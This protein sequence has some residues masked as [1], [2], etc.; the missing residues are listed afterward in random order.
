MT[1]EQI[2]RLAAA[3]NALRPD[4]PVSSLRTFIERNLAARAYRD[5]CVAFAWVANTSTETP[6][7]ILE[8]GPW[9]RAVVVGESNNPTRYPPKIEHECRVHPGE[10]A[11]ACRPCATEERAVDAG[12]RLEPSHADIGHVRAVLA[13]TRGALCGH[14]V[15]RGN[16]LQQ[17]ETHETGPLAAEQDSRGATG[18]HDDA[19]AQIA[20]NEGE[21]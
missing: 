8:P 9:W 18:H 12:A 16:C 15:P 14:G 20:G 21:A 2:E 7:L 1:P 11:D 5:A 17:H 13:Q 3:T 10:W 19:G 4:W 6:R